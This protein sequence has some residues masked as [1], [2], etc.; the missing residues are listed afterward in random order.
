MLKSI[1][2]LISALVVVQQSASQSPQNGSLQGIVLRAGSGEPVAKARVELQGGGQEQTVTTESDGRFLFTNLL[3]GT[4]HVTARRDGFGAAEYGQKWPGGPGVP[5][6]LSAGQ[7]VNTLQIPLTATVSISGRVSDSNGQPLANALVQALKS[8]YQGELRVL[9]PVQQVRTTATGEFRL[10]WLPA[11]R[12]YVNVILPGGTGNTQLLVN[13]SGRTDPAAMYSTSNQP[14]AI[15]GQSAIAATGLGIAG[16]NSSDAG[17]IY[18]P[19]TPYIQDAAPLDLRP[20]AEYKG[21]NL[22]MTP[23]RK[24]T[25]CGVVRNLPPPPQRRGGARGAVPPPPTPPQ[26][27][28]TVPVRANDPCGFGNTNDQGSAGAV[29]L[30]PLDVELRSALNSPGN[31]YSGNVDAVTGQFSIRNVL[32]GRYDLS[33]F[34]NSMVAGMTVDVRDRDVENATLVLQGASPLPTTITVEG[35][36]PEVQNALE[37]LI[38]VI[39]SDPPYQGR[40]PSQSSPASGSFTIQN[41]SVKDRRVYVVPILN[42]IVTVNAPNV[43]EALKNTYVKSAKLGGVEILNTGFQFA[44]EP[45]KTLE[46]VL[47]ANAGTLAGRVEDERRQPAIGVFVVL[48]PDAKTARLFR[49]D[50]SRLTSTDAEG[51]FEVKGLPPGDYK[52]FALDGFEKDSWFDPDFFK[53]YEDRGVSA[54]VEEGKTQTLPAPLAA[55]RQ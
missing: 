9:Y 18:F 6:R 51:R 44:G 55:I 11:G 31:R 21:V 30:V 46:I 33:T 10:Y 22:Q 34:I 40:S 5:I 26:V 38:V 8:R 49:T 3:P 13:S 17:P 24:Y 36:V 7:Q 47:G 50:M 52:A 16:L 45:D 14:R 48:V 25:I 2:F 37:G 29:Q 1:L 53:P 4:Y 41:V 27:A 32:P 43:P 20:G 35:Q 12:Y 23:V 54:R 28:G 15:L 19:S 39:G 42:P